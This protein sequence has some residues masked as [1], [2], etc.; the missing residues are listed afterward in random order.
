MNLRYTVVHL[1]PCFTETL[2]CG[3]TEALGAAT[4]AAL[5]FIL[6]AMD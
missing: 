4:F 3:E 1:Q 5:I 2:T 6:V